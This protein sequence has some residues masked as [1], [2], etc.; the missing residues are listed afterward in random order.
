MHATERWIVELDRPELG[1]LWEAARS[2]LERNKLKITTSPIQLEDLTEEEIA[3]ICALLAERRPAGNTIRVSLARLDAV[4][5]TSAAGK[6]VVE[7]LE[8]LG[9]SIDDRQTRRSAER[10]AREA[11]WTSAHRH[12]AARYPE[13]QD[14]LAS[15]QRSG[16]LTRLRLDNPDETLATTLRCIE[17]LMT[18]RVTSPP[19]PLAV[20]ATELTGDAHALDSGT[21]V[22]KLVWDAVAKI[23]Q[24]ED[25]RSAWK[26]FRVQLDSVS[27]SALAFM[28][29][30]TR[31]SILAAACV[32]GE[33]IRITGRMIDAGLGLVL[34]PG[35]TVSVCENPAIVM[36]AADRLGSACSPIICLEGMP[37]GAT[38]QLLAAVLKCGATL[39]V[40][41]DFDFGGIAIASH[42]IQRFGAQPWRMERSDYLKALDGPNTAL[43]QQIGSTDWDPTLANAMNAH[44]RAVHE[45]SVGTTLLADLSR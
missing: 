1:R 8:A 7:V 29:P 18:R 22:G 2:R 15:V 42:V 6:G 12:R 35:D 25:P 34:G 14:W 10:S 17:W 41:T 40:H 16:L 3:A 19:T 13:V 26:A 23:S 27:T 4:L 36:L 9:G 24:I 45:E 20:V 33:P 38:S 30:G 43:A 11:T 5:R 21:A 31:T 37:S 39:Q 44:Q 32:V 28:V